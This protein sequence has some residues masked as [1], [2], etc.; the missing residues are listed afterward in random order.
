MSNICGRGTGKEG[1]TKEAMEDRE[2]KQVVC[3][4]LCVTQSYVKDGA[5]QSVTKLCAKDGVWQRCVWKRGCD[6]VVCERGACESCVWKRQKSVWQSC[7]W[8]RP[9]TTS[10]LARTYGTD[11]HLFCFD[12]RQRQLPRTWFLPTLGQN[13]RGG[14][15]QQRERNAKKVVYQ[16]IGKTSNSSDSKESGLPKLKRLAGTLPV[17]SSILGQRL[18]AKKNHQKPT[19]S[20]V[21]TNTLFKTSS[22]QT[23]FRRKRMDTHI[24]TQ[25]RSQ[26]DQVKCNTSVTV[27]RLR[28]NTDTR[29]HNR[30]M[31]ITYS[32]HMLSDK[33]VW[34][35]CVSFFNDTTRLHFMWTYIQWIHPTTSSE[36]S[37]VDF[38]SFW[39][40]V[41]C[42]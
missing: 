29:R 12:D 28:L 3:E 21:L 10:S 20:E 16:N 13:D 40:C 18:T 32:Q 5:Q 23:A 27:T 30:H 24:R 31:L 14:T 34:K 26:H 1:K 8:Q 35:V 17:D 37:Q 22:E 25:R 11:T 6:K 41:I 2:V 15:W 38:K 19:V 42:S 9:E 7:V 4:E 36:S 33:H 39:W